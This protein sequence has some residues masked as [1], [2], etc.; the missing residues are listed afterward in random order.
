MFDIFHTI[1][2]YR[3]KESPDK[4]GL[5]PERAHIAA[6]PERRYLWSS[7]ILVILAIMSMSITMMLA[8]T[9]YLMLP[10]KTVY[11]R[12]LQI[13]KYFSVLEQVQPAE[14]NIPVT[15]LITEQYLSEYIT[16]RNTITNDFDEMISRWGIGQKVYWFSDPSVFTKFYKNDVRF[17]IMQFRK[18]GLT[19]SVKIEW[20]RPLTIG[21]W[22]AQFLT[23]D[24][25]PGR[26]KVDTKIWRATI[27]VAYQNLL[28][29]TK[30]DAMKNPFGF[31]VTNY[32]LGYTG[33]PETSAHYLQRARELA[34]STG[35]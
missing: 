30:E 5:Y 9:I 11:P 20:I 4:L 16:L 34:E 33:T 7:R 1:F 31:V 23:M 6:M 22:Q 19:R 26:E 21:L 25:I 10:Q 28:F 12:L 32:S 13:N 17:N 8:L 14:V 24:A 18:N 15:D 3:E 2:K 29:Q 27:R 35:R